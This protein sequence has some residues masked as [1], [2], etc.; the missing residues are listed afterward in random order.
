VPLRVLRPAPRRELLP[1]PAPPRPRR[2]EVAALAE[3]DLFGK[4]VS[5]FPRIM[6]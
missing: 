2:S 3:H 4:A 5:T 6:L 1:L